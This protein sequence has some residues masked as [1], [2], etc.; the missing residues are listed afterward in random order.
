M[1]T[2]PPEAKAADEENGKPGSVVPPPFQL[3]TQ[4]Q[5]VAVEVNTTPPS[6]GFAGQSRG[7][8][9]GGVHPVARA[10]ELPSAFLITA[11]RDGSWLFP[12]N[13][14]VYVQKLHFGGVLPVQ[15]LGR[16]D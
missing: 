11:M 13:V 16:A 7:H 5:V 12:P 9:A 3:P 1:I 10:T 8:D 6:G 4:V 14:R 2:A 15:P